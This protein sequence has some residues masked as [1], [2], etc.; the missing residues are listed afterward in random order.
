ISSCTQ[1]VENIPANF[2]AKKIFILTF[3]LAVN[4]V[5]ERIPFPRTL[6]LRKLNM[7]ISNRSPDF[8]EILHFYL[9]ST[10]YMHL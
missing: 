9:E 5:R 6:C 3:E 4:P 10:T 2:S 8:E 1:A 7:L